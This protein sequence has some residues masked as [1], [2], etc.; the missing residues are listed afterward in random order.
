MVHFPT[1]RGVTVRAVDG[2]NLQVQQGEFHGIV[3]ESGCGKTSLARTIAGL[4]RPTGGSVLIDGRELNDWRGD[5]LAFSRHVQ[6]IFQDP[7]ASL[8]RRQTI[9]ESLE[10][11]LR[12]HGIGP[13][14]ERRRR[15]AQLLQLVSLPEACLDRLP[16]ALSGGQR[17]RVAIAR[18]LA[19]DPRILICDEPL[20]ALDVSIRAQILN[21]FADLQK[22]LDLSIVLIAHDLAIV[23][24]V[25]TRVSVMYL[26]KIVETG[27][28]HDLFAQPRHPY[29][30]ALLDAAPSTDP[31]IERSRRVSLLAG[32]PPSPS[33]PPSG[34]R[35]HTRCPL[36][37]PVCKTEEPMLRYIGDQVSV[38][39]H[40]A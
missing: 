20:S 28:A 5:R 39:C 10:E 34:C 25:C 38:A 36:V 32:D 13:A 29:T 33:A 4:Q 31:K 12:I 8:S 16:R 22:K 11:P 37:K 9:Q 21:L 15:V 24:L 2:V 3:G 7:L 17:Q 27:P 26:G 14:S 6:F 35:F 30:R 23:R 19:L 1:S 18:A 40:L